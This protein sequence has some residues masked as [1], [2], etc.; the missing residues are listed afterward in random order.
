MTLIWSLLAVGVVA[1]LA[2]RLR[3]LSDG[4]RL[5]R[6]SAD[7]AFQG[8]GIRWTLC[9]LLPNLLLWSSP[10][11][12]DRWAGCPVRAPFTLDMLVLSREQRRACFTEWWET[13]KW[14]AGG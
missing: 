3:D 5:W 12:N 1:L 8:D 2:A 9:L 7:P 10:K 4:R 13:Q 6:N 14:Y 11:R